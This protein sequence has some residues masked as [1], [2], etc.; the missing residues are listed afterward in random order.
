MAHEFTSGVF[1]HGTRA[2]HGLGTVIDG[3]LTPAAMFEMAQALFPVETLQLYGGD[4]NSSALTNGL[5]AALRNPEIRGLLID[6]TSAAAFQLQQVLSQHLVSLEQDRIGIWRPDTRKVLGTASPGY[7]IIGN[8][9]LLKIAESLGDEIEMD[10][11][12]VL[13][14][15]A[16][17][18]F[19]AN[20]KG[21]EAKITGDDTIRRNFV[22]YLGHDGKTALGMLLSDTRVVCANTLALSQGQADRNGKHLRIRHNAFEVSQIDGLIQQIDL[23]RQSLPAVVQEYRS[24]LDKPMNVLAFRQYVHQVYGLPDTAMIDG[25]LTPVTL[26][27]AMPRKWAALE[28]AYHQGLG[29]DLAG[30]KGTA[31]GAFNAI[32][33]IETSRLTK[34]AGK[35]RM[36]STFFGTGKAIVS[37]ARELALAL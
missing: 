17:V 20:I 13:R 6:N 34:G 37:R 27:Q 26:E 16:K 15:G 14:D 2:W 3:T 33:E 21:A 31:W 1:A 19:T 36:H 32:T 23:A 9:V 11:V 4:L 12:V 18:A 29:T 28:A 7:E 30:V 24:L 5:T 8:E 35:R 22:G 25:N 10:T